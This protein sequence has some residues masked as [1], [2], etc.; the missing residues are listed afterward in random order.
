MRPPVYLSN[1][2]LGIGFYERLTVGD[3]RIRA[4]GAKVAAFAGEGQ[5][6]L[7]VVKIFWV[8]SSK[9]L[10]ISDKEMFHNDNRYLGNRTERQY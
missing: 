6:I 2:C 3:L 1:G 4:R 10:Q 8:E 7:V 5:K 9:P